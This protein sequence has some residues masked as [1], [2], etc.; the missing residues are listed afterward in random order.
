MLAVRAF[1]SAL[2]THR[3][4]DTIQIGVRME[5]VSCVVACVG[6][7]KAARAARVAW[8]GPPGPGGGLAAAFLV[9][10]A[11]AAAEDALCEAARAGDVDA[12]VAAL[13]GKDGDH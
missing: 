9:A 5:L 2:V 7:K 8:T 1:A 3:A 4:P 11:D 10:G 6:N 12:F 13:E